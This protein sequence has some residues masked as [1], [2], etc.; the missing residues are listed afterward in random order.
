MSALDQLAEEVGA[1]L[2]ALAVLGGAHSVAEAPVD[3]RTLAEHVWPMLTSPDERESAQAAADIMCALWPDAT[4]DEWWS[5]PLGRLI[6]GTITGGMDTVTHDTAA[7]MLG[8]ARGTVGTLVSRGKLDRIDGKI[9][10][11][12]VMQR[13]AE[14]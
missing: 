5:T 7:K 14:R 2:H 12:S 6:A 4:P 9:L 10:R 11:S 3:A 1:R 8:V 13:L